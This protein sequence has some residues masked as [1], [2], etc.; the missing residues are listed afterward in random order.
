MTSSPGCDEGEDGGEDR[1]RRAGGDRDLGRR[2][3]A[4]AVERLDLGGD[5]LAQGRHA[6]HRRVLV[7]AGAHRR[8]DGV[9]QLR[10]A[11][12]IGEA[13]AEVDGAVLLR[14]APT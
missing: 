14:R 5:P 10:I 6:G 11:V 8:V 3:V 12:E 9:D 1:L 2:V 13:L 4:A 7:Q